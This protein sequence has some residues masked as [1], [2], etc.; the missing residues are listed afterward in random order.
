MKN[1]LKSC[2]AEF[3]RSSGVNN[4]IYRLANGRTFTH[5]EHLQGRAAMNAYRQLVKE[6]EA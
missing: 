3:V 5:S 4:Q 6:L 2:G 1:L